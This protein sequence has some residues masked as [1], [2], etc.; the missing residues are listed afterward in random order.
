[1][2][3]SGQTR[4]YPFLAWLYLRNQQMSPV[5]TLYISRVIRVNVSLQKRTIEFHIHIVHPRNENHKCNCKRKTVIREL[6]SQCQ[7]LRV[8]SRHFV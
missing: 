3:R 6:Q 5:V 7:K 2:G 8:D 4:F 1:M